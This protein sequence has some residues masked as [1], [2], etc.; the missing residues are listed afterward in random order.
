MEGAGARCTI[1]ARW[2]HDTGFVCCP[3]V[4]MNGGVH[5]L[6]PPRARMIGFTAWA[7]DGW[8]NSR[9]SEISTFDNRTETRG[10]NEQI[11]NNKPTSGVFNMHILRLQ[12]VGMGLYYTNLKATNLQQPVKLCDYIVPEISQRAR[13]DSNVSRIGMACS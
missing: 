1:G 10:T 6:N 11:G 5:D 7:R 12:H 9:S 3:R 8:S 4:Q 13:L 2:P